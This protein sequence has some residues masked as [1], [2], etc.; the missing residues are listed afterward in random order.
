MPEAPRSEC[1][2]GSKGRWTSDTYHLWALIGTG[3][4][5]KYMSAADGKAWM[6]TPFASPQVNPNGNLWRAYKSA[7]DC[8]LAKLS[9][10]NLMVVTAKADWQRSGQGGEN[11]AANAML[12]HLL[13]QAV[14]I[15]NVLNDTAAAGTYAAAHDKV[16]RAINLVL[17]DADVGAYKD[18]PLSKVH[19]QDGNSLMV[20]PPCTVHC[21]PTV[22][23]I[24][25][26][27]RVRGG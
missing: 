16:S 10:L 15:A 7:V 2:S 27:V 8:S 5:F 21:V 26:G 23:C 6:T 20:R 22:C 25:I 14:S 17:W 11:V 18:N 13:Q 19:P 12:A 24:K 4:V 3:N 1:G 9:L